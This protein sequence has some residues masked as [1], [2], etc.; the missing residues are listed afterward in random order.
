MA[1]NGTSEEFR[2]DPRLAQDTVQVTDFPLCR[3]LLMRNA[4]YPWFILVPRLAAVT[5][6]HRLAAPDLA[7]LME[8]SRVLATAMDAA[9]APKALNVAKLG[10]VVPQLHLHHVA[11]FP[12]DAAWP[13]PV[14]GRPAGA[15]HDHAS[16]KAMIDRLLGH[17]ATDP[18]IAE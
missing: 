17:L 16:A 14:W 12:G 8:E 1:S 7:R 3:V 4:D 15:L 10:N 5:E 11:R 9:F 13:G 6:L 18:E 2:L